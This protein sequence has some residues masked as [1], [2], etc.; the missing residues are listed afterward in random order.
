M[1]SRFNFK[2]YEE[3]REKIKHNDQIRTPENDYIFK[4]E[5][6]E[7]CEKIRTLLGNGNIVRKPKHV[8]GVIHVPNRGLKGGA[9]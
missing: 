9:I 7:T 4:K 6:T 8:K 5:W 1:S 3:M 2:K